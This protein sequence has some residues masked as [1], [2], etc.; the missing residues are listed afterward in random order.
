M[1]R[2]L[3][4]YYEIVDTADIRGLICC[5]IQSNYIISHSLEFDDNEI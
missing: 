4:T 3:S 2:S 1:C 5:T